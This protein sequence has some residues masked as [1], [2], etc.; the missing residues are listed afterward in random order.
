MCRCCR[1]KIILN[2]L[3]RGSENNQGGRDRIFTR[4]TAGIILVLFA[5]I[6]LVLLITREVVFGSVGFA[7]SAFLLGT[8]GYCS[9][10]LLAALIF[11]GVVLITGKKPSVSGKIVGLSVL[12]FAFLVCLVHTITAAAIGIPYNG[13]GEY[14]SDCYAAGAFGGEGNPWSAPTG[15][16]VIFGL[17]VYPVAKVTTSIGG[18]IIFSL[19]TLG[20]AYLIYATVKGG[21]R[22]RSGERE[23]ADKM[24]ES[25]TADTSGLYDLNYAAPGVPGQGQSYPSGYAEGAV[26]G[27][28]QTSVPYE[29]Q[30]QQAYGPSSLDRSRRLYELGQDFDFKTKREIRQEQREER[31]AR[32]QQPQ[33]PA[34][35]SAYEQG[36]SIL[37]PDRGQDGE[38]SWYQE[39]FGGG[40][41]S[42][43]PRM[44]SPSSA[45]DAPYSSYTSNRIFDK[46]SYFNNPRRG[47]ISKEQYSACFKGP[48]SY[49][50]GH[51]RTN[52]RKP[53][54]PAKEE[55]VQEPA[56][57][58]PKATNYSDLYADGAESNIT[59]SDRPK[60]ILADT[61]HA[62]ENASREDFYRNDVQTEFSVQRPVPPVQPAPPAQT[63]RP[64]AEPVR[65]TAEPARPAAGQGTEHLNAED[66]VRRAGF[67]ELHR[68]E[69]AAP[70][71]PPRREEPSPRAAEEPVRPVREVRG[72]ARR[73]EEEE[74][75]SAPSDR[76]RVPKEDAPDLTAG[77]PGR[78]ARVQPARPVREEST[79]P[80][81]P[82][83][84]RGRSTREESYA[85]EEGEQ[86]ES[87]LKPIS[88]N[89]ESAVN[90]FDGEEDEEEP[91]ASAVPEG[92]KA[93][94][95]RESARDVS[96]S[97]GRDRAPAPA[98]EDKPRPRHVYAKYNPP[99]LD[100]LR[101]YGTVAMDPEEVETNNAIIV[102]TLKNL[103][104]PCEV[105]KVTRGPSVTRYDIS[106]PGNIPLGRVLGCD[107][108][109]ALRL[110]AKDGVNIQTNY[111]NG[112]ISI[113]V[114]N[115][116][117]A[118][119]GLRELL[120]SPAFHADKPGSLLFGLG[121]DIEGKA[122]CGDIAKMK[123]L[124]VSGATGSGK[125]ICLHALIISLLYKY[126]PEDLRLI[127]IDPKQVDFI[128]YDKLPH[129]MVNE[130]F[131]NDIPKIL[132]VLDWLIRE[133]ERRYTIFREKAKRGI[134]VR[135]ID[136]YNKNLQPDEE[137]LPKIVMIIDELADLMAAAKKEIEDRIQRL[138]QKSR[139]AGIHLVLATQRPSVNVITGVIK[140]NLP[141][142]IAL[143]LT[144]EVDSRTILD[145]SGAEKLLGNGDMLYR[146]DS[147][148]FPCRLQGALVVAEEMHRVVS[149]VKE[150]NEAYFDDSV[151]DFI[152][153]E[154]GGGI[155]G[156]GDDD[157]VEP[158]Y[159]DALRYVVQIKQASISMIQR[160]C[161]VGY[162]KAGK[163]IEWMEN[164][165]YISAFD[166][167]RARKVLLTQEEFD[168][169][170]GDYGE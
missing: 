71:E 2:N 8:F 113:E 17:I 58:E 143:K 150:H 88:N 106:V 20:S 147:M 43:A 23:H 78:E 3:G 91:A 1:E 163:I 126:S 118:I 157:S 19:L 70:S 28:S 89:L 59:Y 124:L 128:V 22:R 158:V 35:P 135:E 159:I 82:R 60:K 94:R 133:M 16:G 165:G 168:A 73:R 47:A 170:Y 31:R 51:E 132:N 149:Y 144:Q 112:S 138:T 44:S 56:Q 145:E 29:G 169:K 134:P 104:I 164:M 62:P 4:E 90:L 100:L 86:E 25:A 34:Q 95:E 27:T 99:P 101:D 65:P 36:R 5:A 152:N 61:P 109:L 162:P 80:L 32:Q 75:E 83:G 11:A 84:E 98:E 154:Q 127:I 55:P 122:V 57:E 7:V 41:T 37:Y 153:N 9:Y 52:P 137:K 72:D 148:T 92:I 81:R 54:E 87:G 66:V 111:E 141:T 30:P 121:K 33:P 68:S 136:D 140:T 10:I 146:T 21:F 123:H 46:D 38:Y 76:T 161:S 142:R 12:L 42:S 67:G 151:S 13:Y 40:A 39:R 50:E 15:G 63:A 117:R 105:V 24:V 129:L 18:Y 119:V 49:S 48:T 155:G 14:L 156:D 107:K 167:A 74:R 131:S 85:E 77:Q 114:P 79:E 45:S 93:A 96:L 115:K 166:G 120:L 139:A 102:E 64:A 116:Q 69:P 125:T 130:I 108:E 97:R 103:K 6:A 26:P 160:R 110:H 53:V